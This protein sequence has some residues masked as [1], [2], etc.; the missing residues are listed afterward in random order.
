MAMYCGPLESGK[1]TDILQAKLSEA[2]GKDETYHWEVQRNLDR[3]LRE[4]FSA[5]K[6]RSSV[7]KIKM[8]MF[9]NGW[10]AAGGE[11][12][13]VVT[14]AVATQPHKSCTFV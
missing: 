14:R 12:I 6:R 8:L 3:F 13:G 4:L 10:V 7:G 5:T 2:W 9:C 1:F 11:R